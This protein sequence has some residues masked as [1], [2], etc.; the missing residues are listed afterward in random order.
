MIRLE[1]LEVNFN[2]I[3]AL[4]NV[5]LDIEKGDVYGVVGFSGAG[6]STL[7]RCINLLQKP[8]FGRV[9][10][11]GEDITDLSEK[12]L[13]IKRKKIGMIFQH[14]NLMQSRNVFEN[15]AYSLNHLSK[16]EREERVRKL[17]E[18]VD[19]S[20]KIYSYPSELSGGQKQ[21]VAIARALANNPDILLCDEAT[22]ALDPQTTRQILK[23]LK[24]LNEK[25]NLTI[26]IITHEM[27]VVKEI[28]NKVAVMDSGNLIEKGDVFE[29]FAKAKEKITKNFIY[30]ENHLDELF[31][32]MSKIN[33]L[34]SLNENKKLY[35][36]VYIGDIAQ[37]P[38]ISEIF[39]RFKVNSN[40]IWGNIEIITGKTI[41][42]LAIIFEGEKE[43]IA[44]SIEF[45]KEK[46]AE[47][48]EILIK[49][50]ENA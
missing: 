40:I 47:I 15:V 31:N 28:C 39:N 21:R 45:L 3:K 16:K 35:K 49:E 12:E 6:K 5:S 38:L 17:L 22:S 25:L 26:V 1:N 9:I 11:S 46:G 43:N 41:G 23:L 34:Q 14:F 18:L 27:A 30:S 42:N 7:I 33:I 8:T 48:E 20:D 4:N 19:I 29:I 37:E 36:I 10:I 32:I 13:R 50:V 24:K 44:S 2:G